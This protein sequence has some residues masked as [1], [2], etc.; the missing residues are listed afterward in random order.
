MDILT[1]KKKIRDL[2]EDNSKRVLYTRKIGKVVVIG[3]KNIIIAKK[4]E[5]EVD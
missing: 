2:L 1:I 3:Y 5:V 4:I